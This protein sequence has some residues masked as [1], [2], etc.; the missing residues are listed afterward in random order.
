MN[1]STRRRLGAALAQTDRAR[2]PVPDRKLE[3]VPRLTVRGEAE[4]E[5][6]A[7]QI[8]LEIG[9]VNEGA[10]ASQVLRENS[11]AMNSV[12]TALR[13]AGLEKDEYETGMF[14]IRPQ[15]SRRPRQPE[16]EWQP[17][18]IGYQVSNSVI[19][20]TKR[21]E[22]AG[23]IIAAA[24]KAGANTVEVQ[25]F[26]LSDPRAHRSEAIRTATSNAIADARTLAEAAG[27]RLVRILSITLD[28]PP[29]VSRPGGFAMEARA[30]ADA[31]AAPPISPGNV[32]VRASITVVYEI[33]PQP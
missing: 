2:A 21:I 8:R 11:A 28:G 17:Q 29:V 16:A 1:V 27:L 5:R 25:G 24:N 13:G 20:R 4:L 10:E 3:D 23:E 26:E 12:V 31:G 9:V 22:M 19:V 7:D 18:I 32:T 6:P 15:Y 14:R 30:M 33:D